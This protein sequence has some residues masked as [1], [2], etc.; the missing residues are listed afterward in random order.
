MAVGVVS[1][2]LATSR[3]VDGGWSASK[4]TTP[5]GWVDMGGEKGASA[6]AQ[7]GGE[8]SRG[9]SDARSDPRGESPNATLAPPLRPELDNRDWPRRLVFRIS[10]SDV[11]ST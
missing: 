10:R 8:G 2:E 1:Y 11:T 6:P 7:C 5:C 9:P 4:S 3:A